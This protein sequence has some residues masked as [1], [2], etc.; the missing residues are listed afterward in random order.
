MKIAVLSTNSNKE[1]LISFKNKSGID[2][3]H[4]IADSYQDWHSQY[5]YVVLNTTNKKAYYI[6]LDY[7]TKEHNPDII[8]YY[9]SEK[10]VLTNNFLKIIHDYYAG[11]K[12][13]IVS[14]SSDLEN[15]EFKHEVVERNQKVQFISYIDDNFHCLP[16]TA[17]RMLLGNMPERKVNFFMSK[18]FDIIKLKNVVYEN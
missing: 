13:K 2:F 14:L 10:R 8:V 16:I 9:N 11:C 5:N 12:S 6:G 7:I 1:N 3:N 18:G 4:I 17:A 15:Q